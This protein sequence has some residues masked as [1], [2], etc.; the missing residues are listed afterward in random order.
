[1]SHVGTGTGTGTQ[2][3]KK[4][5]HMARK[6]FITVQVGLEVFVTRCFSEFPMNILTSFSLNSNT[7][8]QIGRHESTGKTSINKA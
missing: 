1:M 4:I 6:I 5:S 3:L 2:P 8:F 7:G